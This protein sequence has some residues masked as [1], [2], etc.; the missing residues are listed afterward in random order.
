MEKDPYPNLKCPI[1]DLR[2]LGCEFPKSR[3][4]GYLKIVRYTKCVE[5]HGSFAKIALNS[6]VSVLR[7][8]RDS[9][10]TGQELNFK[11]HQDINTGTLMKLT[12]FLQTSE[13]KRASVTEENVSNFITPSVILVVYNPVSGNIKAC[14]CVAPT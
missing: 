6:S 5:D 4:R 9:L 10:L 13:V 12:N 11:L 2:A 7:S 8:L 3:P 14:L 1:H